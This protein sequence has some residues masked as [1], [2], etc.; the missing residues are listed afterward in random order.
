MHKRALACVLGVVAST[1][2]LFNTTTALASPPGQSSPGQR[3]TLITG[4]VVTSVDGQIG[5]EPAKRD[6]P[7]PFER[8][9]KH[10]DEYVIPADAAELVASGKLDKE[11]FNITGLIRQRYDDAHTDSVPLIIEQAA[12]TQRRFGELNMASVNARKGSWREVTSSGKKVWLNAKLSA[13]LDVSVPQIGAPAAWQGGHTGQGVT[14]AVLDS[15]ID[16]THPDLAGKVAVAKDF[17]GTGGTNDVAGHGTHVAS[18]I[19]GGDAK[20]RG[21]APGAR[22]AVGKVLDDSGYGQTDDIIEGMRWA[23]TEAKAKVVNMSLGGGQSDGTDPISQA[24]NELSKAHGTLF[25]TAAGNASPFQKVSSPAAADAALA[26]A[27]M[28]KSGQ[29]SATSSRGPR[30][31]D[32]AMKPEIAAPGTDITAARAKDSPGEGGHVAKSGT[33]MAAPHVAGAAAILAGQHPDWNGEAIKSAL[34]ATASPVEAHPYE[35]GNGRVDIARATTSP[36]RVTPSSVSANLK[37][38][39]TKPRKNTV[40][41]R[42]TGSTPLTLSLALDLKDATGQAAPAAL[43]RLSTA[44]LTIAAGKE[45]SVTLTT[46]PRSGRPGQYGGALKATTVDGQVTRTPISVQDEAESY[47]LTVSLLDRDG[48]AMTD[49]FLV[50]VQQL[51]AER[52]PM[53]PGQ[54]IRLPGGK[55]TIMADFNNP[56]GGIVR[57]AHPEV[58]LARDTTIKLDGRLAKRVSVQT[59]QPSVRAGVWESTM[60]LKQAAGENRFGLGG[61]FDA[62]FTEIYTYS[63]PNVTSP[64]FTYFDAYRL[65][66]PELELFAEGPQRFEVPVAG[67]QTKPPQRT[68]RSELVYGGQGRPEDL[69]GLVT[70]DKM[71]VLDLTWEL[72]EEEID[73]RIGYVAASGA[74]SVALNIQSSESEGRRIA[75]TFPAIQIH[76]D[77]RARFVELAKSGGSATWTSR[78]GGK[79]RFELAFPVKGHIPGNVTYSVRTAD[80]AA[81]TARYYGQNEEAPPYPGARRIDFDVPVGVFT[82]VPTSPSKERVEHFT[83]GSWALTVGTARDSNRRQDMALTAG[84]KYQVDWNRAVL[85][86]GF[87]GTT[88]TDLGTDHPW[89]FRR[90]TLMS[91]I[92]PFYSDAAGHV[93]TPDTDTGTTTGTTSLYSGGQLVGMQNLPGRG[94]FWVG[95]RDSEFR[96]VAE[97][98]REQSWWPLSTKVSS[99]WTFEAPF[100]QGPFDTPLPLL[101]VR[102]EPPVD[103]GNKSP[104]GSVEIPL[105]VTRQDGPATV[106]SLALEYSVDDGTT[107]QEAPVSAG[108]ATVTNPAN[109]FVSLRTNATDTDGNTVTTTVI[110]AY[111][112]T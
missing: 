75:S 85:S 52:I 104:G 59:D 30:L 37:W 21:V 107:W 72:G 98:N 91:V 24:V 34:I 9:K 55:Y 18:T 79:H 53:R 80:L 77:F 78:E 56:S 2:A 112:T 17:T 102:A 19:V 43:A 82:Y 29:V 16:G 87:T 13:S 63:P 64:L 36:V 1:L 88:S 23:V 66:E 83:P 101:A 44:K 3:V 31:G 90:S 47:D 33:S 14:V 71:V 11:L 48:K 15:G 103:L 108:K 105:S 51:D 92:V 25:V 68:R 69:A 6:R 57:M 20:F 65:E 38:P 70:K 28:T 26:V 110:R 10:G 89:A 27:N 61:I 76:P 100:R 39:E 84:G 94:I 62:R 50:A 8:Q 67:W 4:D 32:A 106:A 93:A 46:T 45:A 95:Q 49:A 60:W 86:P 22:L 96:L 111:Q 74:A 35:A 58:D 73:R 97:A 41:Y 42:N 109:G 40:T 54:P 12:Q 81:V 5:I 7:V 99:E